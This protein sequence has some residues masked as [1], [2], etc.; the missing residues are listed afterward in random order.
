[1]EGAVP[2]PESR[3]GAIGPTSG[4]MV[5]APGVTPLARLR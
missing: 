5:L 3:D 1:M 2:R 4:A